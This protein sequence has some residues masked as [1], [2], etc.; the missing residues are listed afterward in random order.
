MGRPKLNIDLDEVR[1]LAGLGLLNWQ[2]A[3]SIGVSVDTLQRRF[4]EDAALEE[5][6]RQKRADLLTEV[7]DLLVKKAR[8]GNLQAQMFLVRMLT[9]RKHQFEVPYLD[10][11]LNRKLMEPDK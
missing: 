1:R 5:A 10:E 7:T 4:R 6:I 9:T 2:I 3:Q 11:C 8:D